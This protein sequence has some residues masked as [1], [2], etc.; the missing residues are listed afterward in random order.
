MMGSKASPLPWRSRSAR[1]TRVPALLI[2][3]TSAGY[4]LH[5][6]RKEG[7]SAA[8]SAGLAFMLAFGLGVIAM[9]LS[10][11]LARSPYKRSLEISGKVGVNAIRIICALIAVRYLI[12]YV[13]SPHEFLFGQILLAAIPPFLIS[14]EGLPNKRSLLFGL[15]LLLFLCTFAV[16][17][18][19][20]YIPIATLYLLVAAAMAFATLKIG[21]RAVDTGF[22]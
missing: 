20:H 4:F 7:Y 11:R 2:T 22:D 3:V 13:Q 6:F 12:A 10:I 21:R 9:Y 18:D 5:H 16:A 1:A 8:L 15:V 17:Y 19:H 14:G